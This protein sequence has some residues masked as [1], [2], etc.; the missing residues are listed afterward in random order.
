[1]INTRCNR[2]VFIHIYNIISL[3]RGGLSVVYRRVLR[4]KYVTTLLR[5]ALT[6][7]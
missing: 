1:M 5:I 6:C 4:S 7:D 3:L 2:G